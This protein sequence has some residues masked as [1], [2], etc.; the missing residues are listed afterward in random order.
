MLA[1]LLSCSLLISV[2]GEAV[3]AVDEASPVSASVA[4]EDDPL[5]TLVAAPPGASVLFAMGGRALY[6]SDDGGLSWSTAGP[7]PPTGLVVA[8]PDSPDLLLVG[9]HRACGATGDDQPPLQRSMDGGKTWQ[10]VDG[11]HGIRPLAIWAGAELAIGESCAGFQISTDAGV[12]WQLASIMAPGYEVSAFAP[13]W[14]ADASSPAGLVVGTIGRTS[15]IW[16]LDLTD[17]GHLNLRD[18]DLPPVTGG[19]APAVSGDTYVIGTAGGIFV[20]TDQGTTW[21]AVTPIANENAGFSILA[22]VIDPDN[23]N[24]LYAGTSIGVFAS[25]DAGRSWRQ[26]GESK[27]IITRLVLTRAGLLLV[28]A[29]KEVVALPISRQP[30]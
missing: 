21:S 2:S 11:E 30:S 27:R 26:I 8:A 14:G 19:E 13:N 10:A 23:P 7:L 3:H 18:L 20:S 4:V 28:Q 6:R 5:M 24:H 9:Y 15:R 12:T 22:M 25:P 29:G 16:W 17:P 1:L